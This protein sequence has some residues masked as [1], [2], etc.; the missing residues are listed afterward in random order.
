MINNYEKRKY[1]MLSTGIK[2]LV[3]TVLWGPLTIAVQK[4]LPPIDA[5]CP[6]GFVKQIEHITHFSLAGISAVR[7]E[8]ES[9]H[10]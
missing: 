7:S 5:D 8:V 9:S 3:V 10:G 1:A 2:V 4:D 6:D